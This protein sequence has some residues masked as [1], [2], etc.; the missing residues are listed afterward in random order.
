M[1]FFE[2]AL[3]YLSNTPITEVRKILYNT[4]LDFMIRNLLRK[5]FIPKSMFPA[6]FSALNVIKDIR[7]DCRRSDRSSFI[8]KVIERIL[9]FGSAGED[10]SK[11]IV[12]AL[13]AEMERLGI[14]RL[15][16]I[17]GIVE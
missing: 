3:V 17:I 9:T 10:A 12:E 7:F 8:H 1:K 2:Y 13:P 5:A 11:E 14:K 15:S 6:V 16:D 4:Q